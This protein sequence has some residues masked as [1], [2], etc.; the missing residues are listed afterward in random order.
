MGRSY[1]PRPSGVF[2]PNSMS[3]LGEPPRLWKP[4][5]GSGFIEMEYIGDSEE[6]L[7]ILAPSKRHY[8]VSTKEGEKKILAHPH[9]VNYLRFTKI[10]K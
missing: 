7:D 6:T 2:A 10:A 1:R 5:A 8:F 3:E 4:K 9:D